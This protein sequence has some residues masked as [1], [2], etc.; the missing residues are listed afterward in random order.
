MRFLYKGIASM[1]GLRF[2]LRLDKS[3]NGRHPGIDKIRGAGDEQ[4]R[5]IPETKLWTGDKKT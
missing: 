4:W 5:F 2:Q 3:E 1:I